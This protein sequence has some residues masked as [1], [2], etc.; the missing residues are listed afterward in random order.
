M[1]D[2]TGIFLNREA[3]VQKNVNHNLYTASSFT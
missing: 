2:L 3:N 1:F